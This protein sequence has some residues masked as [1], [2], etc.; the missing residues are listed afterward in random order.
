LR[1]R[2]RCSDGVRWI[3][4][5]LPGATDRVGELPWYV[6][7]V[8]C[9]SVERQPNVSD[10]VVVAPLTPYVA[11][12][13]VLEQQGKPDC[14]A[15]RAAHGNVEL[16]RPRGVEVEPLFVVEGLGDARVIGAAEQR[17]VRLCKGFVGF[18]RSLAVVGETSTSEIS[19]LTKDASI[20]ILPRRIGMTLPTSI[21]RLPQRAATEERETIGPAR[22]RT[23]TTS[24]P[25]DRPGHSSRA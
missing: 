17:P 15:R 1:R 9:R 19:R 7:E 10:L 20:A 5:K 16:R 23:H 6:E 3:N 25:G 2:R 4:A 13:G 11:T 21:E 12:I 24:L 22:I 14:A 8:A 18:E